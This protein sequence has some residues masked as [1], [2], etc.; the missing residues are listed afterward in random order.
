MTRNAFTHQVTHA[1]A[2]DEDQEN[3]PVHCYM[4]DDDDDADG[5][6]NGSGG[7]A[8][9]GFGGADPTAATAAAGTRTA[10][11]KC[12]QFRLVDGRGDPVGFSAIAEAMMTRLV[13]AGM[14]YYPHY[15]LH[16]MEKTRPLD[17]TS[18]RFHNGATAQASR[19]VLN[20]AKVQL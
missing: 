2:T 15:S 13:G 9:T 7:T 16:S 10:G 4:Y 3:I 8:G 14:R 11:R 5:A 1:L 19:V 17:A 6:G 20:I 12:G 18:L